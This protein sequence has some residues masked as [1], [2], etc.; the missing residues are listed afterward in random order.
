MIIYSNTKS[1]FLD[2]DDNRTI[3][4]VI[5]SHFVQRTGRYAQQP[6][7]DSWKRSIAEMARV[8]RDPAI[9]FDAGIGIEYGLPQSSKRIDFVI[10]GRSAHGRSSLVIIELKQWS[11]AIATEKD[12]III[13]RRGGPRGE[14]EGTHPSYQAW[15][16]ASLLRGFSEVVYDNDITLAPCA[17][18]HNYLPDGQ[19]DNKVYSNYIEKA[20]LF[21]SGDEERTRLRFF[22]KNHINTGDNCELI[23]RIE[24]GRIRPSKSL[25][26][27]LSKMLKG[28]SN[29]ILIDEQKIA[30][31]NILATAKSSDHSTKTVLIIEGGPGTGKSII[32]INLL[33]ELSKLGLNARYVSKN[34]APRSV[35]KA[36]LTET[37]TRAEI[38]GFFT[39]SGCFT[40]TDRDIFDALIVDEAHRLNRFS[41]IY[42]NLG[43]NQVEE[44]IRSSRCTAFFVDED[45]VVTLNDIG[46]IAELE[47][48]AK[49]Q[50]AT[51][52]RMKLSSQFRCSGSD[53]YIAWL[54]DCL[55]IRETANKSLSEKTFNFRVI[56]SP[57]ELHEI[58]V[59]RNN[60]NNKS[61]MVA[62]YCW[63]WKSK[64]HSEAYDIAIPEH[65]YKKRWNLD[66]DGS[67][68][69]VA[70]GS[71]DE[72]GCIHTC[73]GLELDYVGV[74]IGSDLMAREGTLMTRPEN[75]S[76]QDRSIRGWKKLMKTEPEK[77]TERVDRIIRNT[78]KTLMT[79]GMKGCY[80]YCVDPE[81]QD[82]FKKR[83]G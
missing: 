10:S 20:P 38:S 29:F 57:A 55:G 14:T 34:S 71:V 30:F 19:I 21:L 26:D 53:G 33:H 60:C 63:D 8:M 82:Y 50:R 64:K 28:N 42:A 74:I 70:P 3:A 62:G 18:L 13:A 54:D 1:G 73:Q 11:N 59:D 66:K 58:I 6:E 17:Y 35:Y 79:R 47:R 40:D 31:E 12:G 16:Y 65:G 75:R 69:I 39:G 22:I 25:V 5:S 43:E 67:L 52:T 4:D 41:G 77:T 23:H 72:V 83:L 32:A 44:I 27:D 76:S 36:K 51:I 81:T 7:Y 37:H 15:S 80:I 45:Q 49:A 24:N 78:Y 56:D 2:D 68:W 61:R 9:P 48:C 46:H